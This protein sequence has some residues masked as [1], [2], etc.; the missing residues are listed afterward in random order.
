M[1]SI[2]GLPQVKMTPE[3]IANELRA[4]GAGS[5]AVIGIDRA[6]QAGHWFN[7]YF[8]G[9]RVVAIDG[10]SGKV[11]DWPPA[12]GAVYWDAAIRKAT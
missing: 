11:I 12:F 5:H 9:D 10:Q 6:R 2:T 7:A 1:E 4:G 8:D 3:E